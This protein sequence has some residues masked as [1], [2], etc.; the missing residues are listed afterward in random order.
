M[1]KLDG[2][3]AFITGAARG[4]GRTHAVKLAEEGADIIGIDICQ[5][6]ATVA[7]PM[8]TPED[9]DETVRLVEKEGRQMV[10]IQADVRD[11]K[12]VAAAV[13]AGTATLGTPIDIVVANAGIMT[14]NPDEREEDLDQIFTDAFD[15]MARGVW[16]TLHAVVPAMIDGGRGGAIVMTSSSAV[17]KAN[18]DGSAGCDAYSAAKGAVVALMKAYANYLAPYNIRVNALAPCGVATPMIMNDVLTRSMEQSPHLASTMQNAM[19]VEVIEP[20]DVSNAVAW[21]VSDDARYVTGILLNI[22]A[23]LAN[24]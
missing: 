7:Y 24:H 5:Q 18:T 11:R 4:Q 13:Q 10:A 20:E 1:G 17:N 23:G 22:D 15:V 2:K 8:S 21:L 9:L 6:I 14:L 16:N 3:V 12:A 19:P